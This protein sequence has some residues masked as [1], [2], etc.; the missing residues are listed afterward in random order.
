MIREIDDAL[1]D[2]VRTRAGMADSDV[3]VVFDA[4]TT[5]W[6]ARRNAPTVNM[7]LYDIR[8]DPRWRERGWTPQREPDGT[9][10]SRTPAPHLFKLS[11]L[12]T[13][14]TSRPEDEHRLLDALLSTL[15]GQSVLPPELLGGALAGRQ[16][17]MT[18]GMPPPEDRGFA[19]VWSSLGGQL[20]PSI[21]VV[22]T[23]P[24]SAGPVLPAGPPVQSPTVIDLDDRVDGGRER[25]R[26]HV[27]PPLSEAAIARGVVDPPGRRSPA[28]PTQEATTPAATTT[29]TTAATAKRTTTKAA[30]GKKSAPARKPR[31]RKTT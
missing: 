12:V 1:R 4:P 15:L 24:F 13:A 18:V 21:D 11:Y 28:A 17:P 19:D 23:A 6:A 10:S 2:L 25:A 30:A 8:E 22:L 9:I 5:D 7:F 26:R 20:K 3:E 27:P 31:A 29:A 14:W 16:I